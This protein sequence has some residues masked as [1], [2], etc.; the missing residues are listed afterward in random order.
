[1]KKFYGCTF[2]D[3]DMLENVGIYYPIKLEYYKINNKEDYSNSNN[4]IYGVEVI[5]TEY[6]KDKLKVESKDV[7]YITNEDK[8]INIILNILK[9]NEVTPIVLEDVIDD[10]MCKSNID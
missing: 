1:M 10:Y 4:K 5:K 3:K 6:R 8:E 9:A 2:M 7:N